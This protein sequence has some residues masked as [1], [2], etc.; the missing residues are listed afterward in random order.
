MMWSYGIKL[1]NMARYKNGINGPLRGKIGNVVAVS[2]RGLDVLRSLPE[3][4]D[5]EPSQAQ[6]EHRR[7]FGLVSSWLRPLKELIWIGFRVVPEGKTPMNEAV[8]FIFK[9]ALRG[10]GMD[11]HIDFPKAVFSRGELLVSVLE[12]T[13]VLPDD[14]LQI[15]WR[16]LS[17]SAFNRGTD[18]ATFIFYNERKQAFATFQAAALRSDKE[19]LLQLPKG[20]GADL[21][22]GYMHYM[23]EQGDV[24]STTQ[25]FCI[26]LR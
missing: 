21:M 12:E 22:H 14:L 25:Y 18:R 16:N 6:K 24:L 7:V 17:E 1:E 2:W 26:N 4:S 11:R 20:F 8:S 23:S 5:T 10:L 3:R 9:Y 15:K 19:V 13:N